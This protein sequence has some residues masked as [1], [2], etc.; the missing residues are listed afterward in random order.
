MDPLRQGQRLQH[1]LIQH[2]REFAR[3]IPGEFLFA[4]EKPISCKNEPVSRR[5]AHN[6]RLLPL[7]PSTAQ[8]GKLREQQIGSPIFGHQ[9]EIQGS[10]ARH[11]AHADVAAVCSGMHFALIS[12]FRSPRAGYV[13]GRTYAGA[14]VG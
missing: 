7:K 10:A 5:P 13:T 2:E 12:R 14:A 6:V 1:L 8:I 9:V 3:A 4:F 11:A